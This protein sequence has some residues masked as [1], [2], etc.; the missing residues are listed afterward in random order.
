MPLMVRKATPDD[1]A[2]V[3]RIIDM[4][5]GGVV[6]ALWAEMASPT[7]DGD[8][9][10]Y[11]LVT[12]EDGDFSYRNGF[13]AERE[14]MKVGGLIGYSLPTT[15]QPAGLDVPE[16]FVGIEELA[17]LV[18]GNWYIN[19]MAVVPEARG[20]GVGAALLREAE[21]QARDRSSPGLA[22]IVAASNVS[23]ISVYQR[24]G[25]SERARRPFDLSD[26][27]EEPTEAVLMVK[28]LV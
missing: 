20:Q 14:G 19:F 23:A 28:D 25:Y 4:A 24:A 1:A 5:S 2:L 18:P 7:M 8:A 27:G 13:I 11:A 17:N 22:L 10:G 6:P 21:K 12:A 3:L 26:F 16:V 9:V 15:P